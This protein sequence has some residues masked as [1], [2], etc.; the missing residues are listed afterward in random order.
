MVK[1][2]TVDGGSGGSA[3]VSSQLHIVYT[4]ES[5]HIKGEPWNSLKKTAASTLQKRPHPLPPPFYHKKV[6]KTCNA[7]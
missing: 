6:Q 2:M 4:Y 1:K 5:H 3:A 7:L